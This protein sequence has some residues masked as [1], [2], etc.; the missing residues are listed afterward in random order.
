[1]GGKDSHQLQTVGKWDQGGTQ[2]KRQLLNDICILKGLEANT[3]NIN[4]W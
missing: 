4:V 1:M 2:S 3:E